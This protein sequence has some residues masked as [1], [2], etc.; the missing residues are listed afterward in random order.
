MNRD[1]WSKVADGYKELWQFPNCV[2]AV[3]GKHIRIKAPPNS[4]SNFFNYKKFFSIVV[5]AACDA[6]YRFTW[7]DIGQY[8]K[9]EFHNIHKYGQ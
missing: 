3:D 4:G 7:V 1:L 8:G 9:I 5:M 2:G 6:E